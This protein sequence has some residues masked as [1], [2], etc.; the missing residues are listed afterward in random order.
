M[1]NVTNIDTKGE[2]KMSEKNTEL[3]AL[4]A[5][6]DYYGTVVQVLS[7]RGA[8]YA[9]EFQGISNTIGFISKLR[10][11]VVVSIEKIEP[12]VEKPKEVLDMDLTHIK[13]QD[14]VIA[15]FQ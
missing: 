12:K 8:F 3:E 14:A 6:A 11:Q 1:L 4:K 10:E 5:A 15:E 2:F 9:E 13:A 7:T